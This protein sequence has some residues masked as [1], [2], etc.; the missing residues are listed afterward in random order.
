MNMLS[1]KRFRQISMF[2]LSVFLLLAVRLFYINIW[3]G[4]KYI[5]LAQNQRMRSVAESEYQRGDFLDRNGISFTNNPERVLLVF[6]DLLDSDCDQD[7]LCQILTDFGLE[8]AANA[9]N[10]T[11][12]TKLLQENQPFILA[13]N[14]TTSQVQAISEQI[15][16]LDGIYA[17]TMRP[18]Y[19][20]DNPAAHLLGYVG[21]SSAEE[22]ARL[23]K[24]GDPTPAY[25]GKTGLEKQYDEV[26]RGV[27]SDKIAVTVDEKGNQTDS[28][29]HY[30]SGGNAGTAL[31]IRLTLDY[32]YQLIAEAAMSGKTGAA[33]LLDVQNGDVLA[34]V[35]TPGFDQYI[36]Q[37]ATDGDDYMN[38]AL[39]YYPPASVFK[40]VLALAALDN[41]ISIDGEESPF[42][43]DGSIILPGGHTVKC[44][45]STGHGEEDISA[46]LG[47]SCN[48]YFISLG[49]RLGGELIK[50]YAYRLGMTEQVLAGL[51][52]NSQNQLDFN[53]KVVADVANVSI[54][55]KGIRATPLMLARL[56]AAVA[57]EGK[58]PTPRIVQA[59]VDKQGRTVSTLS[60]E[61]PRQ[62]VQAA[63]ARAV[64]R[65]LAAAVKSGTGK[66]L[67]SELISIAGKTGTT[68]DYG[69]WFAGF[70]PADEPHWSIAV[71]IADGE[72]GGSDAG[73]VCREIAEKIALLEDI[74]NT[75]SV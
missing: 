25:S 73:A 7:Y 38:K 50:E 4:G 49:Q 6:P 72:S 24:N 55:E 13:R 43:C 53:S 52:V 37:P 48:P 31:N 21:E 35:S 14:L 63:S 40:I 61:Q 1:I 8:S 58:L 10:K 2:L 3:S 22:Y 18:R 11:Q 34:M 36:G 67:N 9:A 23:L 41:G 39:A 56:L 32:N 68:Q 62:V 64:R 30:I 16:S 66:P 71:Y 54:G 60:S 15:G 46:A 59:F 45:K 28:A 75:S 69:V 20:T 44:W 29:L 57:N 42:T 70:F 65:Y 26:L 33:V 51:N 19:S 27:S 12:I 5:T 47:N 17:L 74:A